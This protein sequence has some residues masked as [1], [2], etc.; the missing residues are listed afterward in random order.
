MEN[1]EVVILL[2]SP[3]GLG[4]SFFWVFFRVVAHVSVVL[5]LMYF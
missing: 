5:G 1:R 2:H 4:F 3:R